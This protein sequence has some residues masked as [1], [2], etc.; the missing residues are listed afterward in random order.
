MTIADVEKAAKI[1][2]ATHVVIAKARALLGTRIERHGGL[3]EQEDLEL[4][5]ALDA[6]DR[7]LAK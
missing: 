6:L 3:H 5:E 7:T 2:D 1:L 4:K